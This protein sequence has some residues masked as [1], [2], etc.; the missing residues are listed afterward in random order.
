MCM[1]VCVCVR[2]LRVYTCIHVYVCGPPVTEVFT[3]T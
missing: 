2:V 1:C 3:L